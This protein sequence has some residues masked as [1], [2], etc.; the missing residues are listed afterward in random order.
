[1]AV[2]AIGLIGGVA[3]EGVGL[4]FGL[5]FAV[6]GTIAEMLMAP[7]PKTPTF[8]AMSS[9]YG[10]TWPIV[11]NSFRLS[12]KVIQASDVT[13]HS[14]KTKKGGPTYSQT[15][16]TGFCEGSRQIQRIWADNQVIYDPRPIVP[17]AKWTAL[18]VIGAGDI[19]Q[20]TSGGNWQFIA[21][22]DGVTGASEPS[23]NESVDEVTRDGSVTWLA[24]KYVPRKKIGQQ[25]DFTMRT[26]AGDET[27]LADAAL[28]E[29]VGAGK[30][31]A[32]RGLCNAV[33]E[34][35]NISKFGNRIPNIEAE[36]LG[37]KGQQ[38]VSG[39]TLYGAAFGASDTN[40]PFLVDD[41]GNYYN[42]SGANNLANI[43]TLSTLNVSGARIQAD[44][45][46][47][48]FPYTPGAG[49]AIFPL[50]SK[51]FLATSNSSSGPLFLYSF[52]LYE[53]NTDGS[54][55]ML[56][57]K[58]YTATFAGNTFITQL[59]AST[60][61]P[62][63]GE[64]MVAYSDFGTSG[65]CMMLLD[66][67]QN[68][69]G[70]WALRPLQSRIKRVTDIT[71][72]YSSEP[73]PYLGYDLAF[74]GSDLYVALNKAIMDWHAG[75][76][77]GTG[78]SSFFKALQPTYPDGVLLKISTNSDG[79]GNGILTYIYDGPTSD[80]GYPF[81]DEG[82]NKAG[83]AGQTGAA[84][85]DCWS[86]PQQVQEAD[87]TVDSVWFVRGYSDAANQVGV[88]QFING[89][90][91]QGIQGA[92]F[93]ASYSSTLT[94]PKA[95]QM[96][97]G[98]IYIAFQ[99]FGGL[100]YAKLG[101]FEDGL[102]TLADIVADVDSRIGIT[103]T[104][105]EYSALVPVIPR[106]CALLDRQPARQFVESL[107]PAFFFD[108]VE[109]GPRMV[110][111]LRSNISIAATIPEDDL[112]A[113][114]D[115][116]KVTDRVQ[117]T[118]NN[119]LEIPKD[120]AL[121]YYDYNHDY[122]Q[123]S[124]PGLRNKVTNYSSGRNTINIPVV[125]TPAEAANAAARNL[126]MLWA[127]RTPRKLSVTLKYI[128]LTPAD[129]IIAQRGG[130]NYIIRV[131]KATLNPNFA[132]DIEGVSED[133]GVYSITV[134][135]P[136]AS[137]TAG[138]QGQQTIDPPASPVLAV[139]D[140]ATLRQEDLQLVGNYVAAAG[141]EYGAKYD[142]ITAQ[143]SNDNS[144]WNPEATLPLQATMGTTASVLGDWARFPVWDRVNSV[145]VILLNGALAN[146][147]E[148]DLV[149][150]LTNLF[151]FEN[152]EIAQA[153]IC[154]LIDA[155][156]HKYRLSTLLRGR[157]GTEAFTGTHVNGEQVVFFDQTVMQTVTYSASEVGATRYWRGLNDAP[158]TNTSP[159]KTL[160]MA[161]RRLMPFAPYFIRGSRD[162]GENLTI[163]G[164]RRMRWRGRPLWVPPETD[165]PVAVEI[166]ILNG[167]T[168]VRTLTGTLSANGSGITDPSKFQAV[169]KAADQ[170]L[171]FGSA[172]ASVS[173]RAYSLNAIVGR[174]YPG[175]KSV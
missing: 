108:L 25:F 105:E 162:G 88:K 123:G 169:Y 149:Q 95:M 98:S 99:G 84:T 166:D 7:H 148:D 115:F 52:A 134:P 131:T 44:A 173:L 121:A 170:V 159:V 69:S 85:Y 2:L 90:F 97:D 3:A 147:S 6:F 64:I 106:G 76:S 152:G 142:T 23:W 70:N 34:G 163:T 127:Q 81:S 24:A 67:I 11:Y 82:L 58:G 116:T 91:N 14:N 86:P 125:M 19:V 102:L 18:T 151:W 89:S 113:G 112:G 124:Q 59:Q 55:T 132:I 157:F 20:P 61:R 107:Q 110:G 39:A 73:S 32:Y 56:G 150:N 175:S 79:I 33:F 138:G 26:Y 57:V 38:F 154:E 83:A 144:N 137:E 103:D 135:V 51:Y 133:T 104:Q 72:S 119:D 158:D 37:G 114:T 156:L 40:F 77:S 117:S 10:Q 100:N 161:V 1:M 65:I 164:L 28:E 43:K 78:F 143:E 4:S 49:W 96:P 60:I 171:D 13:K 27:Q 45:V 109:I 5:G 92:P 155:D 94:E 140:T 101:A 75:H 48:G 122:Q 41:A 47:M 71:G 68:I 167:S 93:D 74:V 126:Y 29:L 118:R 42:V 16:C 46:A 129:V 30:Q 53:V 54:C 153:A 128:G 15:F 9:A 120:L 63:T 145:D 62:D 141:A 172:Q 139:L 12:A 36:I 80:F 160:V 35:F 165:T 8:T 146:A 168:V 136:V 21:M 66:T 130:R 87:G 174:G 111:S 17:P 22:N 31:P 50:G